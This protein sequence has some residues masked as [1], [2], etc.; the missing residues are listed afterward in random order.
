MEKETNVTAVKEQTKSESVKYSN[1]EIDKFVEEL[2][3]TKMTEI[4]YSVISNIEKYYNAQT[5]LA[6]LI[7]ENDNNAVL[8]AIMAK[9]GQCDERL[10]MSADEYF[11]MQNIINEFND[12]DA[13][14]SAKD[15]VK[16]WLK[17]FNRL[18]K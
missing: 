9:L 3:I 1:E 14:K 2:N 13:F 8:T 12:L 7:E 16:Y 11:R 15:S 4:L 5:K 17:Y 18:N 10:G 6:E